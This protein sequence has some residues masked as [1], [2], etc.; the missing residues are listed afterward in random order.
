MT[1]TKENT[2]TIIN[3]RQLVEDTCSCGCGF[4]GQQWL[5]PGETVRCQESRDR[6]SR[7]ANGWTPENSC[8]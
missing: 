1:N 2:M 7:E 8:D 5:K 6:A 3:G 4:H